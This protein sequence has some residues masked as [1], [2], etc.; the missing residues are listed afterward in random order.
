MKS[1]FI[2]LC[3]FITGIL[4]AYYRCVPDIFLTHDYSNY[5][6]PIMMFF[7]GIGIGGDIKSLYVPIKKYKI[8]IIL[9]PLA[10]IF[11]SIIITALIS[12]LFDITTKETI[13]IGSGF[14]YYSLSAIFLNKLAGYEIGMMA[15]ISNMTREIT[16]L[17]FIPILARYCGKLA[18]I[19]AAGATS[20]DTT[21]PIIAKSCGEQF[22]VISIFHGILVDIS[23]PV[24]ISLLYY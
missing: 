9:I 13:A 18:P 12:P 15:L 1:S 22:I 10:T 14:G 21:L 7:V 11:G 8:K 2:I 20:I 4:L 16:A 5:I 3:C 24:I 6:L 23:V 19:S 17:L